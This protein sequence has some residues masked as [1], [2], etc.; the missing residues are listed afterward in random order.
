MYSDKVSFVSAKNKCC[1]FIEKRDI[2]LMFSLHD[3]SIFDTKI[4]HSLLYAVVLFVYLA[5]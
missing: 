1:I 3:K 5:E 2:L 4:K